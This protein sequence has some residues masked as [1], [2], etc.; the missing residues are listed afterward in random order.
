MFSHAL[1]RDIAYD[2]LL[3]NRRRALHE[4]IA[5]ALERLEPDLAR[6]QPATMALHLSEAG[7]MRRAAG[8][9]LEAGRQSLSTSALTEATRLLRRGLAALEAVAP[10]RM[11]PRCNWNCWACSARR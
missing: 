9:W 5:A 7:Q 1:V 4:R 3:R 2:S 6:D 8:L 11:S 10:V